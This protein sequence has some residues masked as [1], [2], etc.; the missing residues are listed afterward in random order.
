MVSGKN[1]LATK[2][3]AKVRNP[4]RLKVVFQ[5][6]HNYYCQ[7]ACIFLEIYLR[8]ICVVLS[9]LSIRIKHHIH[10]NAV[11]TFFFYILFPW[12]LNKINI[13]QNIT[14]WTCQVHDRFDTPPRAVKICNEVDI[15]QNILVYSI[16]M[17][18]YIHFALWRYMVFM[19]SC[20]CMTY[21]YFIEQV[22]W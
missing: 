4:K 20:M 2:I 8:Y 18:M 6:R 11:F 1:Y 22:T 19:Y 5:N 16:Y 7:N 9:T 3:L 21:M 13:N 17:Y 14:T 15:Q 12:E 10:V